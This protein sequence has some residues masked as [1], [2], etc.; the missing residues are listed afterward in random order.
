VRVPRIALLAAHAGRGDV[1]GAERFFTGLR[2]ALEAAGLNVKIV[3]VYN[4]E[5]GFEN[6][7]QTYLRYYDLDVSDFDGVIS[8]KA[9]AYVVRHPNHVCYLMHTMRVYYDMFDFSF[10]VPT[11]ELRRQQRLVRAWDRAALKCPRT[12]RIMAIGQEVADRLARYSGLSAEVLRHPTTLKGLRPGT[13]FD[14]VFMPGRLHK[15]KRV[16]LAIRAMRFVK[17]PIPLLISGSGEHEAELHTLAANDQRI[18]F[19][20]RISDEEMADLYARSLVVTFLPQ[21]EDLGLVTLEAFKS[22]KPVITCADSGEPARLVQHEMSGYVSAPD[23]AAIGAYI[24]RLA[25][26][27]GL[28]AQLGRQ[29]EASIAGISWEVVASRLAC[30]LGFGESAT[31]CGDV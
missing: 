22:G 1:G 16:E 9:P 26:D 4:D 20:G 18:R 13:A 2:D 17:A 5:S 6:I 29:G 14:H 19:I 28:A 15:W 8:A 12:R 11:T 21:R 10:P 23:P 25:A 31:A 27:P 24:D 7:Q 3:P 30:A